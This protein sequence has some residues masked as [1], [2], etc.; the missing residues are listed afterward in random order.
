MTSLTIVC[1][2]MRWISSKYMPWHCY[3][4]KL[5][6]YGIMAIHNNYLHLFF[7]WSLCCFCQSVQYDVFIISQGSKQHLQIILR[8]HNMYTNQM[9]HKNSKTALSKC[10][11]G[12]QSFGMFHTYVD[13]A[14]C[15][16]LKEFGWFWW[17]DQRSIMGICD[18]PWC[19]LIMT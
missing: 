14:C 17:Y 10:L 8:A 16:L 19:T 13:N 9:L 12:A 7:C 2:N 5:V 18:G 6:W 11:L 3:I 4:N 1:S 15:I